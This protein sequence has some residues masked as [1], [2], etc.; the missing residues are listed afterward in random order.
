VNFLYILD[1]NETGPSGVVSV[2]RNKILN[3][4]ELDKIYLL[5]NKNHWAFNEFSKIKRKNFKIIK[6]NF[7]SS[8]EINLYLKKKINFS[9]VSKLLRF[10]FLPYELF[11]NL[12]TFFYLI[13]IISSNYIDT[14]FSHNGGWPGGILNRIGLLSSV[15]MNIK[16]ILIIHNYPVKKN[17]FNYFF[18]KTNDFII[19]LIKPKIITVSESCKKVLISRNHFK[20]IK[21]IYNGIDVNFKSSK[22]FKAKSKKI[23]ISYFG[24]IQER[25]GLHL[26]IKALNCINFKNVFLNIYGDGDEK[27]KKKLKMIKN[28]KGFVLNFYKPV[29]NITNYLSFTDILVLPSI[30][31][32]SFGMVLI[33]AMRQ[34]VPVI[35][36][37]SGGM[38]EIVK[39]NINGL[40]FKNN[41]IYDLKKKLSILICSSNKRKEFGKKGY[42][43]FAKKFSNKIFIKEYQKL[44]HEK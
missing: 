36:S 23:K 44:T 7:F 37:D 13:Q 39:N 18:I 19:N 41:N 3:W 20:K 24:K 26:L 9:L 40:T 31:Y 4:N 16:K 33:E 27:Y 28:Q 10:I 15:G 6:L 29:S 34:K 8:H 25:K 30:K 11:T 22:K 21:V 42:L 43:T 5:I 14:I 17:F 35:C 12:I 1:E 32:E 38:K 2:V